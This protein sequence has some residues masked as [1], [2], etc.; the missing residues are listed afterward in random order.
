MLSEFRNATGASEKVG[1]G[2]LADSQFD[3]EKA[4]D[5]FFTSGMADQAGSRGGR[6]AAEALYRRYKEPDEDHIGV[7]GVQKFCEDLG[8]EPADIVMLVI[9]YHMGAAVMCEYSR[10]E[11]VSGLVK[12]GAETLTRLRSKLPELRASLAKADTFRAVY[13]FAYDFSREKG[14]KCV[15]LDSAVGMWRLLLESPHAGPNAWSL[16]DDWVAF[17][18]ARHSNRAIAK[19]TWQ[20]LLDFIKSVKPDFSNFDENSAWPYLLDEFVEHMREKRAV[21]TST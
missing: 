16:V 12:L 10:E 18:E 11:F 14:Q 9:S 13:A 19:D 15:Q 3:C 21:G 2:C 6:R 7:D 5:D 1:L 4:I 17:L 20:Q 8:V